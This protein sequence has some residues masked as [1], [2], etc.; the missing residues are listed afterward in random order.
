MNL[1][2]QYDRV[3]C[4]FSSQEY[5]LLL[6]FFFLNQRKV[7]E[8]YAIFFCCCHSQ[9]WFLIFIIVPISNQLSVS[10]FIWVVKMI[11]NAKF[12]PFQFTYIPKI[13]IKNYYFFVTFLPLSRKHFVELKLRHSLHIWWFYTL[14]TWSETMFLC[15]K[16]EILTTNI[17]AHVWIESLVFL[18]GLDKLLVFENYTALFLNTFFLFA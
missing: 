4:A 9:A 2:S 16:F 14:V 18:L 13:K 5:K 15:L 7:Y 17:C 6:Y 10:M 12:R 3:I 1:L 11:R 8:N